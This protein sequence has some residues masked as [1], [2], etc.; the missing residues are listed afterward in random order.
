MV[1]SRQLA[2]YFESEAKA[3]ETLAFGKLRWIAGAESAGRGG[4]GG[5]AGT[6]KT[7]RRLASVR[8]GAARHA[9]TDCGFRWG[10]E[11]QDRPG[12]C[13]TTLISWWECWRRAPRCL[14]PESSSGSGWRRC[15]ERGLLDPEQG[16]ESAACGGAVSPGGSCDPG[17]GGTLAEVAAG[18]RRC[19]GQ[20]VEQLVA[21][22]GLAC[23]FARGDAGRCAPSSISIFRD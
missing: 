19:C 14:P 4:G 12:R 18:K 17:R 3:W 22:S 13:S 6:A 8:P 23:G 15:C 20:S 9:Q 2:Q 1:S 16:R 7:L 21:A 10:G 11:L 5:A